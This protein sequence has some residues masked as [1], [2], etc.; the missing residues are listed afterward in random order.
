MRAEPFSLRDAARVIQQPDTLVAYVD[1][2]EILPL[3]GH[4][5]RAHLSDVL[6][7][8]VREARTPLGASRHVFERAFPGLDVNV[9][10]EWMASLAK[11][12]VE[13][14]LD[15]HVPFLRNV[16]ALIPALPVDRIVRAYL[17][18]HLAPERGRGLPVC[19]RKLHRDMP[20][21][22]VLE[23]TKSCNFACTMCSSRTGGFLPEQ[24]MTPAFFHELVRVLGAGAK[25]IRVNGYGETTIVPDLARYLDVL[26]EI[27]FT[28]M[29]EIIT[30]LSG[31]DAV[32]EDLFRRGFIMLVSW[33]ATSPEL[34]ESIRV[35]AHYTEMLERLRGLGRVARTQPERLGLLCT[36]QEANLREIVPL[37]RLAAEVGAGL[38]IFNMVKEAGSETWMEARFE[39]IRARFDQAAEEAARAGITLRVPD[40]LGRRRLRQREVRRSSATSCDRPWREILVRWDGELDVCNMFNPFSYGVLHPPGPARN[41][42]SRFQRLWNGPNAKLFRSIVNSE[43]PHPYCR[44]CYFLYP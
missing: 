1:W 18:E 9:L 16:A 5:D 44:E 41:L 42:A 6:G 10:D 17:H 15:H 29:R 27:A 25:C 36:I 33:D 34:F 26:D 28:G 38:V 40:H 2:A 35:G 24:T 39:E 13:D 43:E 4:D 37:V 3:A 12:P 20:E 14:F 19:D 7:W 30:N 23:I 32:C 22:V 8:S 21:S 11:T 31:P